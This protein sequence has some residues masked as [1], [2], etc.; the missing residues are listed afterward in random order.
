MT[1]DSWLESVFTHT[2]L[3]KLKQHAEAI[4]DTY[5]PDMF[6]EET[7]EYVELECSFKRSSASDLVE[8]IHQTHKAGDIPPYV[9]DMLYAIGCGICIVYLLDSDWEHD[10]RMTDRSFYF[11]ADEWLEEHMPQILGEDDDDDA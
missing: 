2:E 10:E 5:R 11:N 1:D 7:D 3:K 6:P 4:I 8:W 9:S